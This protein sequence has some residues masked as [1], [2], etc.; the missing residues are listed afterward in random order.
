ML[1]AVIFDLDGTLVDTPAAI[2]STAR[3]AIGGRLVDEAAVRASIGLPLEVALARA[4]EADVSS[5][6]VV[7][8][9]ERYRAIWRSSVSPR[10]RELV[11]PGVAEGL[12]ELR[13]RGLRLGVATGKAQR[14]AE[15]TVLE[16]GLERH[17]DVVAGHDRVPRPKPHADLAR[18]VLGELGAA[19]DH[20][21]VVGDSVLDVAMAHAAD[22][23]SIAVTYG[24][25]TEA[26]LAAARPTRLARS[27]AEVLE[28]LA[29]L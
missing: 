24:A 1:R 21:I 20:A 25:Q 6:D 4:L 27:F 9:V 22:L 13:R 19:P 14:G 8:A 7:R 17:F 15:R 29:D 11:F 5:A 12:V 23:P 26:E 10:L 2:V 3:E 28:V 18:F 16:A